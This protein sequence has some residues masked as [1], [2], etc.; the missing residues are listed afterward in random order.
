M[1]YEGVLDVLCSIAYCAANTHYLSNQEVTH[2]AAGISC[3]FI[4]STIGFRI[5][6]VGNVVQLYN[7]RLAGV[8][9]FR[10]S[11]RVSP[12]LADLFLSGTIKEKLTEGSEVPPFL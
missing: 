7:E 3:P 2:A 10:N 12:R 11:S 6:R 4:P 8:V 1:T 9:I 5:F